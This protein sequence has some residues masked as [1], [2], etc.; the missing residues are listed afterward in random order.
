MLTLLGVAIGLGHSAVLARAV[1]AIIFGVAPRDPLT[2]GVTAVAVLAVA[3]AACYFPARR[4][5][6]SDPIVLLRSE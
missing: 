5:A 6:S 4:A 1:S 3:L 2:Y